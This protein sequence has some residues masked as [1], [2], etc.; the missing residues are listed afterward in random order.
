VVLGRQRELIVVA[1]DLAPTP[2]H[3]DRLVPGI[4]LVTGAMVSDLE[5]LIDTMVSER[6]LRPVFVVPG[7]DPA[8]ATL[9]HGRTVVRRAERHVVHAQGA[10]H[11][12]SPL[13]LQYL[14]RLSDLFFVLARRAAGDTEEPASHD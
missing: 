12:V 13:V 14:N 4:S 7:S 11:E 3:R 6:P 8:S 2:D 1:A 9:D 5:R 10:G